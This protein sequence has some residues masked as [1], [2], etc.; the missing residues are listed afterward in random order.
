MPGKVI[1]HT[2]STTARKLIGLA[3]NPHKHN[4]NKF[5]LFNECHGCS[6]KDILQIAE[7]ENILY[8]EQFH[9]N[10]ISQSFECNKHQQLTCS[11][12]IFLVDIIKP[13]RND[14][15]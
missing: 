9:L 12:T 1:S 15:V 10:Q 8:C 14:I 13:P 11:E 2:A 7:Q 6:S 3:E 4:L 5:I